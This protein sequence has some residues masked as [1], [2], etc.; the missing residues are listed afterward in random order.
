M[1]Y[2]FAEVESRLGH[3]IDKDEPLSSNEVQE[4]WTECL[5]LRE[6]HRVGDETAYAAAQWIAHRLLPEVFG[7]VHDFKKF[8]VNDAENWDR[9]ELIWTLEHL[10]SAAP[11][12]M[13]GV[14]GALSSLN[15]LSGQAPPV[16]KPLP[17]KGHGPMPLLAQSQEETI[18]FWIEYNHAVG[19]KKHVLETEAAQAVGLSVD[20][21]RKWKSAWVKRD[22]K[23]KVEASLAYARQMARETS[24][25]R[26]PVYQRNAIVD[27]AKDWREFRGFPATS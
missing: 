8:H 19:E 14:I 11:N 4:L 1:S 27:L 22:G 16:L 17:R 23:D 2:T 15:G 7:W 6:L 13:N 10:P 3:L 25:G 12:V 26:R 18:L 9:D 24:P 20:A 5:R 21:I